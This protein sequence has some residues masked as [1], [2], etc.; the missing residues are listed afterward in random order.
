MT[1]CLICI[2][3]ATQIMNKKIERKMNEFECVFHTQVGI[4]K[5]LSFVVL[6]DEE[7]QSKNRVSH[8]KQIQSLTT[9]QSDYENTKQVF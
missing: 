3:L 6:L 9:R 2:A 4:D 1:L 5:Q 8:T 7:L